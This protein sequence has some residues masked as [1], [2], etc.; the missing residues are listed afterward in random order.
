MK[1][2]LD[3]VSVEELQLALKFSG[4]YFDGDAIKP[5]PEFIRTTPKCGCDLGKQLM[6]AKGKLADME[7]LIDNM[8]FKLTE[9]RIHIEPQKREYNHLPPLEFYERV[10]ESMNIGKAGVVDFINRG[11]K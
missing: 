1:I 8:K 10:G 5:I 3:G 11:K 2:K 4:L 9:L 6:R 7:T